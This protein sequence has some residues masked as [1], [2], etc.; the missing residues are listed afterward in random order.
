MDTRHMGERRKLIW[1]FQAHN[2]RTTSDRDKERST[3]GMSNSTQSVLGLST[4][5]W[6]MPKAMS[7]RFL[8]MAMDW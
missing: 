3:S 5:S 4:I 6:A 1:P 8:R 2:R 7:Q